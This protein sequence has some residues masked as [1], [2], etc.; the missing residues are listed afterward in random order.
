MFGTPDQVIYGG[1]AHGGNFGTETN[2]IDATVDT[3]ILRFVGTQSVD[4]ESFLIDFSGLEVLLESPWLDL[5]SLMISSNVIVNSNGPS[6][7]VPAVTVDGTVIDFDVCEVS[8]CENNHPV[9]TVEITLSARVIG[10]RGSFSQASTGSNGA[11]DCSGDTPHTEWYPTVTGHD[12]YVMFG[13]PDQV[14]YGGCSHGGNFGDET[15]TIVET[16]VGETTIIRFAGTQSVDAESFTVD[17]ANLQVLPVGDDYGNFASEIDM[18]MNGFTF[19]H[20]EYENAFIA[21]GTDAR[22]RYCAGIEDTSY[23]GYYN[24]GV[25]VLSITMHE[26]GRVDVVYGSSWSGPEQYVTVDLNG[27]EVDRVTGTGRGEDNRATYSLDV[28][29]GDV[30]SFSEHGETVINVHSFEFTEREVDYADFSSESNMQMNGYTFSHPE[31]ENSFIAPGTDGRDTYCSGIE[32]TSYCGFYNPGDGVLSITMHS[33]G[34]VNI[35]YGSSYS[36]SNQYVTVDLNG[37]E[38]DRVTGLGYQV[39]NRASYSMNVLPG[40]VVS[41]SEYGETVINVHKVEFIEY[42]IYGDFSSLEVMQSNGYNF[43]H[44][45]QDTSY[46]APGTEYRG[47]YCMSIP[48]TS[49]CGWAYP[50]DGVVSITMAEA[51]EVDIEYGSMYSTSDQYVTLH[52]NGAEVDRVIGAGRG[53]DNRGTYSMNVQAGDV[54]SF[55]EYGDTVINVHRFTFKEGLHVRTMEECRDAGEDQTAVPMDSVTGAQSSI[56]GDMATIVIDYPGYMRLA[57]IQWVGGDASPLDTWT[58]TTDD[59]CHSPNSAT[60]DISYADLSSIISR[61]GAFAEFNILAEFEYYTENSNEHSISMGDV[62]QVTNQREI[63]FALRAPLTHVTTVTAPFLQGT[64]LLYDITS[65]GIVEEGGE[66]VVYVGF[67]TFVAE[68]HS[69]TGDCAIA[70]PYF[71]TDSAECTMGE[72]EA[73]NHPDQGPGSVQEWTVRVKNPTTCQDATHTE[74]I[75][76]DLTMDTG[77]VERIQFMVAMVDEV[78]PDCR[79][80]IGDIDLTS[81]VLISD[82]SGTW[83]DPKDNTDMVFYLNSI[84]HFQVTFDSLMLPTFVALTSMSITQNTVA[85]CDTDCF[86]AAEFVCEACDADRKSSGSVYEFSV[87]LTDDTFD[88]EAGVNT[89]TM[90]EMNFGL[91]YDRRRRLAKTLDAFSVPIKFSLRDWDCKAPN[92]ILSSVKSVDCDFAS[93]SKKM[94]C[95][96]DGWEDVSQCTAPVERYFSILGLVGS[97]MVVAYA[98]SKFAFV[99]KDALGKYNPIALQAEP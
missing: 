31:Y 96:A 26:P 37:E 54:V 38:V 64:G 55:S 48:D 98:M 6:G 39:D 41:F 79:V 33:R 42:S 45:D 57:S 18:Q 74:Q 77:S 43:S 17:F 20:P 70:S 99:S 49:Y 28:L 29:P 3:T 85:K 50:G 24:P 84:M 75:D 15:T 36:N 30:V 14:V 51:G 10:V 76:V 7:N 1:C 88:A 68:G 82:G 56:S 59:G 58:I 73:F 19:S 27:V 4:A 66:Q 67:R 13:T 2:N 62:E 65:H 94:I 5:Q 23:C 89:D 11:D 47:T 52:L 69:F 60:Q 32:D 22:S 71:N 72:A 46:I 81:A 91:Q 40:D 35:D 93:M 21:P 97:M 78:G 90:F 86:T 80:L 16:I 95:S 8:S 34:T 63:K 25:A 12:G 92:A 61:T 83:V 53:V 44:P 87:V 9:V